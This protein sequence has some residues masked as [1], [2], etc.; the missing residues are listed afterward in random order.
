MLVDD[1]Q[2]VA[3]LMVVICSKLGITNH[4]EYSLVL[5]DLEPQDNNTL[6]TRNYGT[7]TLKRKKEERGR[8]RD[9]K[10]EQLRKK[11]HTDDEVNWLDPSK[12]LREQGIDENSTVLLRR[13]F[14]FSDQNIDSRDPVQLN[15]LY[16]QARDAIL[17]GTHPITQEKACEF[18]G[19]QCQIQFGDY[20]ESKHKP[21]FLDLKEF[22]PQSYT[23]IKG[24][25]KKIFQ[26]HKAC[27]GLNE[28]DAKVKYT[29]AARSLPTYGVT[30]FLVKEKMKGKNKLVPR[31]LGVTKDSVMRL[32]EK[33]KVIM[34]TWPLTTVRR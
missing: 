7:L 5:E 10:M 18:A 17:N 25:E 3:N 6:D 26:E 33:S 9:A 20:N 34:K 13:K 16:V 24:I 28:L 23:K 31:L 29:K 8:E 2:I 1:S 19:I 30:F 4:D 21:G 12:T 27:Q 32:D 22:L 11:L 14:F 15:L